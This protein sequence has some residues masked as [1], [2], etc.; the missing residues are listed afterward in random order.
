MEKPGGEGVYA[1]RLVVAAWSVSDRC[2]GKNAVNNCS[3]CL[4][5]TNQYGVGS[6]GSSSTSITIS[7]THPCDTTNAA[8]SNCRP[9]AFRFAVAGTANDR[10]TTVCGRF[11]CPVTNQRVPSGSSSTTTLVDDSDT[12]THTASTLSTTAGI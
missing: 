5:A 7:G 8:G 4:E 10:D 2:S 12:N 9:M 11:A 1:L 6:S 3:G